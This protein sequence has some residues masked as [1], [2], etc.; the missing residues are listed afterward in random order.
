[1]KIEVHEWP[2]PQD[3]CEAQTVVFELDCPVVF[4]LWRSATYQVL[5]DIC[6]SHLKHPKPFGAFRY[7]GSIMVL[8]A[9][10]TVTGSSG[11]H[12][13]RQPNHS[14]TP[15]TTRDQF[16]PTKVPSVYK[17]ASNSNFSTNSR[18]AWVVG[19]FSNCSVVSY[20]TLKLPVES[21]YKSLQYAVDGTSH[22]S[23]EVMANQS[24]CPNDLNLHEYIAFASL[25]SGHRIQW[26]NICRELP[27]RCLSFHRAEVHTLLTQA[28]WQVGHLTEEGDREWHAELKNV[29][30][31]LVL[32]NELEDLQASIEASWLDSVTMRTITSLT[33]RLLLSADDSRVI[34]RAY[35]LL[36]KA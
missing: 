31:G 12:W 2:L 20:C 28:A 25:R 14:R 29:G 18:S 23:N 32:L 13:H 11:S 17:M 6:R 19:S 24:E 27:T 35:C 26:L 21:S 9:T 8:A 5:N 3:S 22:T 4:G 34:D 36:Q 10:L 16:L 30:F 15:I 33:C 1:M 7:I